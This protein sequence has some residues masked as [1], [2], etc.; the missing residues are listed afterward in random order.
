MK[1]FLVKFVNWLLE[2]EWFQVATTFD[3]FSLSAFIRVKY[4][5]ILQPILDSIPMFIESFITT[6]IN[7]LPTEPNTTLLPRRASI[8]LNQDGMELYDLRHFEGW[9]LMCFDYAV[10]LNGRPWVSYALLTT[11][12][13][14]L[15]PP[16]IMRTPVVLIKRNEYNELNE[17]YSHLINNENLDA[18]I[19]DLRDAL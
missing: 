12:V 1:R 18:I 14:P 3:T 10:Q 6:V 9:Q 5:D 19:S 17:I 11:D 2:K 13:I 7:S 16:Y 4:G 8:R 15:H